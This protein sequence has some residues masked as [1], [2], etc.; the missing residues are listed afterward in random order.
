M[1]L[2]TYAQRK[3]IKELRGFH[4]VMVYGDYVKEL[5]YALRRKG[6]EPIIIE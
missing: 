2:E 5:E 4:W 1:H 3:L 6:I